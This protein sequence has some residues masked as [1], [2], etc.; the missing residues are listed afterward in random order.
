M[1]QVAMVNTY[2][3]IEHIV[4]AA[5]DG[6]YGD[7]ETVGDLTAYHIPPDI[8]PTIFI[9]EN[10]WN[11]EWLPKPV[12]PGEFYYWGAGFKWVFN[13]EIFIAVIRRERDQKLYLCDWTQLPDA[14][15]DSAAWATYRQQLRDFPAT[16]T[17][18]TTLEELVWPTAP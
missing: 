14:N 7:G 13:Q 18:E 1:I 16:I 4:S 12:K 2:G 15:V 8:N 10:Y 3:E 9:K 17:T 11:G 6:T 5:N